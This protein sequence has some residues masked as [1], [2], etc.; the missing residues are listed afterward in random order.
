MTVLSKNSSSSTTSELPLFSNE[1]CY[2]E[3]YVRRFAAKVCGVGYEDIVEFIRCTPIQEGLMSLSV[4]RPSTYVAR[5]VYELPKNLDISRFLAAWKAMANAHSIVRTRIIHAGFDGMFQIVLCNPPQCT[6][7]RDLQ[8]YLHTDCQKGVQLGEPLIRAALVQNNASSTLYFVLTLHHAVYDDWS[9]ALMLDHIEQVYEGLQPPPQ[10]FFTFASCVQQ[11]RNST[12]K[13]FWK[14]EFFEFDAA[15]FPDPSKAGFVPIGSKSLSQMT[16]WET[17]QD[18]ESLAEVIE[19]AWAILC[20]WYTGSS[21]VVFGVTTTGRRASIPGVKEMSGPTI[22]TF[23]LRMRLKKDNS[24]NESLQELKGRMEQI[25]LHEQLGL[26]YIA[27]VSPEAAR[28]CEFHSLLVIQPRR[29]DDYRIFREVT[30]E[31]NLSNNSTFGTYPITLVCEPNNSGVSVEAVYDERTISEVQMQRILN[32]L[33]H[34]L[35]WINISGHERLS[36]IPTICAQDRVQ[37]LAWNSS[38]THLAQRCVHDIIRRECS[39]HPNSSAVCAADGQFSYSQLERHSSRLAA[40]LEELGAVP[41]GFIPIY[42]NKSKWVP[43]AMLSVM[44]VGSAFVLLD[45]SVPFQ[46]NAEIC[47]QAGAMIIVSSSSL[48]TEASQFVQTVVTPNEICNRLAATVA[49]E[50]KYQNSLVSPENALYAT[51][52]SGSTGKPKGVVIQ[53][54]SFSVSAAA[55]IERVGMGPQ[56]RALQF[57]SYAF[58]VSISDTLVTLMAGGCIC[59]PS[60]EDRLNNLPKVI[61]QLQANWADLTP[62]L[63][64]AFKPA[65]LPGLHTIVLGGEALSQTDVATWSPHVRLINA[66]GPAECCVLSTVQLDLRP[67][68]DPL[69]IGFGVGCRCWIVDT[70]TGSNLLPIGAVG[71]LV[72]EGP[73]VGRGYLTPEIKTSS[74]TKSPPWL[75]SML[76]KEVSPHRIYKT[77]D[78]AKFTDTGSLRFMG[79][80]DQQVKLRGQR[81]EL[82]EVEYHLRQYLRS[83]GVVVADVFNME[84]S[85]SATLVALVEVEKSQ[86]T[87]TLCE[88]SDHAGHEINVSP[89]LSVLAEMERIR[90][91]LKQSVPGYMVPAFIIPVDKVPCQVSGKIDRKKIHQVGPMLL[92]TIQEYRAAHHDRQLPVTESE[93]LLS[94]LIGDILKVSVEQ[95][96]LDDTFVNLGGNSISALQLVGLARKSG[97]GIRVIDVFS[98]P[99]IRQL[100]KRMT[101]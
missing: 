59:I 4:K 6:I 75:Y 14:A 64:L 76:L 37:L 29:R 12:A 22:A 11:S 73:T 40:R 67:D 90:D 53:H 25:V 70:E 21:E 66:Y 9:L 3:G 32:Q 13:E 87:T 24:V 89:D 42:F 5:Y 95:I 49:A 91:E 39:A 88:D 83:S 84:A 51:F 48:E 94:H 96:G 7:A 10:R 34:L 18:F 17:D 71:E 68:S 86:R 62:S 56:V 50:W 41:E 77:G 74:F 27:Q 79:R 1:S 47:R 16:K 28:A 44:M 35:S 57:A 52:T 20:S 101:R 65:D 23:P 55:Y 26:H 60:P 30:R 85:E 31:Q 98:H 80:S 97:Y 54:G 46:R 8:D 72:I 38:D 33:S 78:L 99:R 93:I 100:S 36:D 19:L 45:P 63:L 43:V 92:Q 15:A 61:G 2:D 81:L 69:D 82:G 58:D